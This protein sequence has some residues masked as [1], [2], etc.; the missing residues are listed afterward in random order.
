MHSIFNKLSKK[1]FFFNYCLLLFP[2]YMNP[3]F[4]GIFM[5]RVRFLFETLLVVGLKVGF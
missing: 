3:P 4:F 5:F 1:N 2:V